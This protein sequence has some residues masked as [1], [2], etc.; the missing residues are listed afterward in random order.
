MKPF[1]T[2]NFTLKFVSQFQH[3][4][5]VKFVFPDVFGTENQVGTVH[6]KLIGW[7]FFVDSRAHMSQSVET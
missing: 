3:Y 6:R 1:V 7:A 2:E 5:M 4:Y